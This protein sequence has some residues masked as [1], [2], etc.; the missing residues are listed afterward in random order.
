MM[1]STLLWLSERQ[2]IFNFVR[3]NRLAKHFASRFVAGESVTTA[4]DAARDLRA[5]GITTTLD[6]LGESVHKPAESEQARDMYIAILAA[7][8]GRRRGQRVSQ[9]DADGTRC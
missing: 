9:A 3:R 8:G 4:L 7:A 1:R 2:S 5:K 6:L